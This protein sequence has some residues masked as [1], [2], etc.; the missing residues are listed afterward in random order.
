MFEWVSACLMSNE[1]F[2]M[3][4]YIM[5]RVTFRWDDDKV[6][7]VLDEHVQLDFYIASSLKQ[8]SA[9]RH[10]APLGYIILIQSQPI[11]VLAT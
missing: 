3:Y 6:H 1:Q 2:F 10:I 9:G 8:Q 11:F 5:E 4:M 7:F